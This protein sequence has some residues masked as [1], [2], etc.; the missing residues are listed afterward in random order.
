VP[1][2]AYQ[3][4]PESLQK[5]LGSL[6]MQGLPGA[7]VNVYAEGT[8][9]PLTIYTSITKGSTAS[10]PTTID[11]NGDLTVFTAVPRFDIRVRLAT[12]PDVFK[13]LTVAG[14]RDDRDM[15]LNPVAA[16]AVQFVTAAGNDSNDGLS[17]GQAKL[18]VAAAITALPAGGGKI[19]LGAGTFSATLAA[20]KANVLIAGCGQ[21]VTTL[22]GPVSNNAV[23]TVSA[24]NVR[25]E[26]LTLDGDRTNQTAGFTLARGVKVLS[27]DGFKMRDVT[28][29][30][31]LGGGVWLENVTNASVTGCTVKD[32]AA[33]NTNDAQITVYYTA[34]D[35]TGIEIR[36]NK[37]D[38]STYGNG[39][40]KLTS[41]GST[42]EFRRIR[43]CDNEI[44]VGD[45]G[46]TNTLG[47]ECFTSTSSTVED[48]VISGNVVVGE[49]ASNTNILGISVG[50]DGSTSTTG[51]FGIS[52]TGNVVRD[53]R[54]TSVELLGSYL[55]CTG[56]VV[57]SS[58]RVAIN[59]TNHTGGIRGCVVSDNAIHDAIQTSYAVE[60]TAATSKPVTGLTLTGNAIYNPAGAGINVTAGPFEDSL[61]GQNT[62]VSPG[63]S[64]IILAG[65]A[66]DVLVVGN[67]I[68]GAGAAAAS[69]GVQV[70]CTTTGGLTVAGNV[71]SNCI[72]YG[73]FSQTTASDGV[74]VRG[75][76]I[77][78]CVDGI[79]TGAALPN[80]TIVDNEVTGCSGTGIILASSPTNV[81]IKGNR[82]RGN[83][84]AQIN[85]GAATIEALDANGNVV[86]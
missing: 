68:D 29:T 84:T 12:G 28:V 60:I 39:G 6:A 72:R 76:T 50:G 22:K 51:C 48:V 79:R 70:A 46:G 24:A 5:L 20:S 38:G 61:I 1:T 36:G 66:T 17:L 26:D 43:I 13:T 59:S 83:T 27:V 40:I 69:D 44:I 71:L 25:L 85:Y 10:N 86:T 8:T 7:P 9:T 34:G 64:G 32:T 41:L 55:T 3:F 21:G 52:V 33:L 35:S 80:W 19:Q 37:L 42:V 11:S 57:R 65:T 53:C 56:N 75:N 14:Y 54:L 58:G 78:A 15:P 77:R 82:C 62:I 31:C 73:V 81:H 30:N 45:A 47:I 2:F 4:G 18:T 63:A 16:D 67:V 49:N 74:V 23:V